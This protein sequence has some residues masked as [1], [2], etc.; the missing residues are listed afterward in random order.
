M[1]QIRIKSTTIFQKNFGDFFKIA[2]YAKTQG[3]FEI[4]SFSRF[5]ISFTVGWMKILNLSP[6]YMCKRAKILLC[7]KRERERFAILWVSVCV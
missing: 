4:S 3:Q 6:I 5:A 7:R 2:E 1:H